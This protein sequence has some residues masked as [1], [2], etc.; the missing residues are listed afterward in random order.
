M[1]IWSQHVK[2][3]NT[4]WHKK[5]ANVSVGIFLKTEECEGG[6]TYLQG[7]LMSA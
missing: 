3:A 2:D 5:L 4:K 7:N 6:L 1:I